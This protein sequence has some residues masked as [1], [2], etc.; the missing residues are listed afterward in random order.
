M[1]SLAV[2]FHGFNVTDQ[3]AGTTDRLRPYLEAARLHVRENDYGWTFL[4]GVLLGNQRRAERAADRWGTQAI[5]I[6]HSNGCAILWRASMLGAFRRLVFINPA[7]DASIRFPPH[8][9]VVHV[10]HTRHDRPVKWAAR[11]P[12]VIWGRMGQHGYVERRQRPA[13][14]VVQEKRSLIYCAQPNIENH[15]MASKSLPPEVQV[16]GHSDVFSKLDYW[17]PLIAEMAAGK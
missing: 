11:I 3:G 8:L 16:S 5:G 9:D 15:D 10:F 2:L 17:G 14:F 4:F 13:T 1:A 7:L 6:G 12:W